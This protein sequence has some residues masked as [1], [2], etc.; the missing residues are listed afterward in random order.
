MKYQIIGKTFEEE[1]A[2]YALRDTEVIGCIFEGKADGESALKECERIKINNCRF[3]LRYPLWHGR[4][5][6]V[7]DSNFTD[8]ARAPMWYTFMATVRHSVI[9]G[10]KALRESDDT[11]I[12]DSVIDSPEFG[13]RCKGVKLRGTAVTSEYLFFESKD[14]EIKNMRMKGKYSFQ[15]FY[16]I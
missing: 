9:G 5:F 8:T 2:L 7:C 12:E 11:L 10:V 3:A 1:R 16:L 13:W 4:D 6:L 15:Y 14:I